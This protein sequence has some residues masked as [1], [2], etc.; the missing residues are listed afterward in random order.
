MTLQP[1][2]VE[3]ILT[4]LPFGGRFQRVADIAKSVAP[5]REIEVRATLNALVKSEILD[6]TPGGGG[7]PAL[8]GRRPLRRI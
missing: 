2:M 3:D 8:Y 1:S 7:W 4:V 5:L 6:L